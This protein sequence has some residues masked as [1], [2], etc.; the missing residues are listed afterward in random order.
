MRSIALRREFVS[1]TAK[2]NVHDHHQIAKPVPGPASQPT[3]LP[4]AEA[5]ANCDWC[6]EAQKFRFQWHC[7]VP[8]STHSL[9]ESAAQSSCGFLRWQPRMQTWVAALQVI[10]AV[11]GTVSVRVCLSVRG[12]QTDQL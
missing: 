2:W 5:R 11:S 7:C 6:R 8:Q 1:F 3:D 10:S 4:I 12:S 9:L